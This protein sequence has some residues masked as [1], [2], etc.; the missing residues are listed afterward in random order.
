[1]NPAGMTREELARYAPLNDAV[2][3]YVVA[4]APELLE[5]AEDFYDPAGCY[6]DGHSEGR[7]STLRKLA[8]TFGEQIQEWIAK[9]PDMALAGD[10]D[11]AELETLLGAIHAEF[12]DD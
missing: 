5:D 1:M 9:L 6:D 8:E 3:A 12:E 2:A 4:H 10:G 11:L 7:G